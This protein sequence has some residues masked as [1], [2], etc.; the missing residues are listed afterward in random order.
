MGTRKSK[1]K[2]LFIGP[3]PPPYMGP[4]LATE[5]ILNSGLSDDF[6]LI[7][8]DT[9]DHRGL[10]TL[11]AIDFWNIYLALKSYIEM[12]FLILTRWPKLVYIPI[13]QTTIGYIKDSIYIIIAKLLGRKVVCH[14]RGGNFKNWLS[15]T[16]GLVRRYVHFVHSRIDG[17]IVLGECLR[18]LFE[19]INDN[20]R[21][22]VVPNGRD[23]NYGEKPPEGE[24]ARVLFLANFRRSKGLLQVLHAIPEVVASFPDVEFLFAG[25][26]TEADLKQEVEEYLDSN[27]GLP[28]NWLGVVQGEE[29]FNIL[30]SSDIFVFP[31]FYP[32]EGHPWVIIEAMAAGL[33][34]ISTDHAAISESVVDGV[35]GYL[36]EKQST[37]AV[38][39]RIL[40]LLQDAGLRE[41]M[42]IESKRLYAEKFTEEEMVR[43]M[44]SVFS[45][46]LES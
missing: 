46:V 37:E 40:K 5:I 16:S 43:R 23:F 29:K 32:R 7:H 10:E 22:Y 26:W 24:H 38:T 12:T 2:I 25:N 15:G 39:D 4:T 35:N 27:P 33:P 31:T 34:I 3:V 9:S 18:H 44:S 19:D 21:I 36:V 1:P 41:S 8:L 42:G 14:L 45:Q 28:V 11:G 13:S 30:N 20:E 17:Q 6:E